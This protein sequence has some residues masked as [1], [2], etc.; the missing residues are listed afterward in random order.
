M[1]E[2]LVKYLLGEAS[3]KEQQRV[4]SWIAES[5]ANEKYYHHFKI[6]WDESRKIE[7][8][9]NVDENSAWQRFESFLE[10]NNLDKI[11]VSNSAN[12]PKTRRLFLRMAA[13]ACLLLTIGIAAY[14]YFASNITI[15]SGDEVLTRTL[16]DNSVIIL[17][18]NSTLSYEKSFNQKN[19]QVK[20]SGEAFFKVAPDKQKPFIIDV[21][22]VVV[23][24]VGTS[25]NIKNNKEGTEVIVETGIVTVQ[26]KDKI[27]KLLPHQKIFIKAGAKQLLVQSN[28][29][30]LYNYY[31][32]DK[33]LCN[34]T[35]L[36]QLVDALNKNYDVNIK[37]LNPDVANL[38]LT[39]QFS[40]ESLDD[41]LKIISQTL[42]VTIEHN[43]KNEILIK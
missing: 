5:S 12:E 10:K 32:T 27:V 25:F 42:N 21:S 6:I 2:I 29:D 3:E 20:L 36:G 40:K 43:K 1:D 9:S 38:R 8:N 14:F 33:F 19:R 39:T 17:N 34:N 31:R 11:K 16:P 22:D 35:P 15:A 13:A 28:H 24:V 37:I 7:L 41:I 4:K 18:K 30:E 23:T 26:L